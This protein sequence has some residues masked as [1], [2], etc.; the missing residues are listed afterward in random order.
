MN[1]AQPLNL[2]DCQPNQ[3]NMKEISN[4]MADINILNITTNEYVAK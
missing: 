3:T 2:D 4:S 1:M